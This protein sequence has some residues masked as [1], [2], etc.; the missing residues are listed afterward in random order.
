MAF[1]PNAETVYADGPFGSPLQPAKSQIRALLAQYEAA[2]DAYSS[3]AGSI[4]KS[5]RA[6]LFAD[7]AHAADVTA[8]VYA[9]S[10]VAYNGIYRKSGVS[11]AGS[12]SLI[13]PLPFSFI[14]ASDVGAGT[15]NAI[16]A[17]TSIPVSSSALIWMNI[18]EANTASPV[19]V[20]F[21]GGSSL[22]IKTNA[23]NNVAAGGL[24]AGMIVMG[25]VSG[26]TFRLVSDQA[27]AAIVAAA[28]AAQAAAEAAAASVNIKNV[29]D[30]VA[31]KALNTVVTTL[32]FLRES[33]R[34]GLFKWTTGDY[35][36]SVTEDPG[37]GVFIKADAIASTAGAW[38]RQLE[39]GVIRPEWFGAQPGNSA[40]SSSTPINRA[41]DLAFVTPSIK[42]VLFA[43]GEYYCNA[44][45]RPVAKQTAAS[46]FKM[47]FEIE[48]R[49]SVLVAQATNAG[50]TF[51]RIAHNTTQKGIVGGVII[52]E[53]AFRND[54]DWQHLAVFRGCNDWVNTGK[55]KAG[56]QDIANNN[57]GGAATLHNIRFESNNG[58]GGLWNNWGDVESYGSVVPLY[59][60]AIAN[61]N[62]FGKVKC[63]YGTDGFVYDEGERNTYEFVSGEFTVG[64]TPK[65]C[66]QIAGGDVATGHFGETNIKWCEFE[67]QDSNVALNPNWQA[68]I[69]V[70]KGMLVGA[71][72]RYTLG[73]QP[74]VKVQ[75]G[76]AGYCDFKHV[77]MVSGRKRIERI[78]QPAG[79]A[80]DRDVALAKAP[81]KVSQTITA[82]GVNN[83]YGAFTTL[84]D[85]DYTFAVDAKLVKVTNNTNQTMAISLS[86]DSFADVETSMAAGVSINAGASYTFT[87]ADFGLAVPDGDPIRVLKLRGRTGAASFTG[88]IL[89]E[90]V[91]LYL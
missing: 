25:V 24:T 66:M 71:G 40:S 67:S 77:N 31:L 59:V 68:V 88:S 29:V 13:L 74:F 19:T 82:L 47:P 85:G 42:R 76:G 87:Q 91:A 22:T 26:T 69:W 8:W 4:A 14:V 39:G 63:C 36:A 34:E 32:A 10:T 9:D 90:G 86:T 48:C 79:A 83:V 12:W 41:F 58:K 27:N 50:Q 57:A 65:Y 64:Q 51:F 2:I 5:T 81:R 16:Q 43:G 33:G 62:S 55:I 11:G 7:L 73:S 23:G 3:G 70:T 72:A 28:E 56:F 6:L 21:N 17:T 18:S 78:I 44:G 52:G 53:L 20:S 61:A 60:G 75:G 89:V 38:V 49:N 1:S 37:E 15:P 35:S 30:R 45:L 84:F 54:S 46:N 80:W